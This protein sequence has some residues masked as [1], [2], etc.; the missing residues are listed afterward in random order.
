MRRFLAPLILGIGGCGILIAL[1]VWQLQRLEWKEA[2]IAEIETAIAADPATPGALDGDEYQAVTVAGT[3]EGPALRFV[4]SG[5]EE[6]I[7]T[8]LRTED[9]ALVLVDLGLAP[10]RAALDLPEGPLTI[11]GNLSMPESTGAVLLTGSVNVPGA[12]D[13]AALAELYGSEETLIVASATDPEIPGVTPLPV[14]TDE[15]PNNHL[16]YAVQWFGLALVWAAMSVFL[17]VR[18][19]RRKEDA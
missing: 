5:S 15:I 4:H 9:G 11:T 19:A 17:A 8:G 7:L 2:L 12:R 1:G 16:G 18:I 14:S 6:L 13:L 3:L 10:L